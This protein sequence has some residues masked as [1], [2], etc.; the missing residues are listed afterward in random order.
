MRVSSRESRESRAEIRR[1]QKRGQ[2]T[3]DAALVA[4]ALSS[5]HDILALSLFCVSPAMFQ[6]KTE[7]GSRDGPGLQGCLYIGYYRTG[8]EDYS[9]L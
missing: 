4:V 8:R 9:V 3:D 5:F 6:N 7:R 2:E 1:D